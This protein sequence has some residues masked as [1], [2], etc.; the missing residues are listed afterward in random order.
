MIEHASCEDDPSLC[1]KRLEKININSDFLP[2]SNYEMLQSRISFKIA[3][4]YLLLEEYDKAEELFNLSLQARNKI[5]GAD[6]ISSGLALGNI[7]Y[8]FQKMK[9][10]ELAAEYYEKG[11]ASLVTKAT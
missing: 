10:Y 3:S 2:Q 1:I 9:K 11:S 8:S 6:S 7:A 4:N 5:L